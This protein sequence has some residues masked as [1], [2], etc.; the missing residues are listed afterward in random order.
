MDPS[1]ADLQVHPM[2]RVA[3]EVEAAVKSV[4]GV[5][6]AFMTTGDKQAALMGLARARDLLEATLMRVVAASSDVAEAAG[7]RDVAGWLAPTARLDVGQVRGEER[8]ASALASRWRTVEAGVAEGRVNVAQARVIACCLDAVAAALAEHTDLG[9]AAREGVLV[10]AEEQLVE[11]AQTFGPR[12]LRRLGE[13]ILGVVA[14]ELAEE[15]ER[16]ALEEAE[17]RAAAVTSL[18]LRRRGDGSTDLHGRLPDHAVARLRT[19]LD[20]FT[21]PRVADPGASRDVATGER[22]PGHR[23]AGE[24]FVA[25]LESLDPGL[26]PLHGGAATTVVVTI[27]LETLLTGLGEATTGDGTRITAG[28]ARRLACRAGLV[29]VVLDG[30]SRPLDVGRKRRLFTASQR[31]ALSLRHDTCQAEGCDV[32]S[33]WCEAHHAEPWSRGGAT[34]LANGVL[35]CGWHHHRVHDPAYR[36]RLHADGSVRFNKRT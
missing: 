14:P 8:T 27:D 36:H 9:C 16:T 24:A 19:C 17:R 6:P 5:D 21:S 10:R 29:P 1:S 22:L 15:T 4:T 26:L 31:V 11:H 30:A 35:L 13:R 20:A 3:A 34:N 12:E 7:A 2:I 28:Q 33:T 23:L 18:R 32:P 25:L